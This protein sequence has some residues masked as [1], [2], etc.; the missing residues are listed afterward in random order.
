MS[1]APR[2]ALA[3]VPCP[4]KGASAMRLMCLVTHH[5]WRIAGEVNRHARGA[6]A[7]L[8]AHRMRCTRC[9]EVRTRRVA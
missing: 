4:R 9:H 6:P 3:M 7:Q 2:A 5:Q 1:D 8:I